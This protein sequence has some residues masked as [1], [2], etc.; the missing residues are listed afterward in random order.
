MA[1]GPKGTIS[2]YLYH[3]PY[4][5]TNILLLELTKAKHRATYGNWDCVG[6]IKIQLWSSSQVRKG[7]TFTTT[8]HPKKKA[9]LGACW[10]I[11]LETISKV[12]PS[13]TLPRQG[14]LKDSRGWWG[15][16]NSR[17]W[18]VKNLSPIAPSLCKDVEN[19]NRI[20]GPDLSNLRREWL[21]PSRNTSAL[22]MSRSLWILLNCTSMWRLNGLPYLVTSL[23]GISFVTIE[24]L[25]S[26]TAKRILDTL[27]RVI[28]IY[29]KAG[30]VVQTALMDI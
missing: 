8:T 1:W 21:G 13:M 18:Y 30:F 24:Y 5:I 17:E 11:S 4:G 26:R 20:F 14:R 12:T 19:A 16:K 15:T 7:L 25:Q 23:W 28:R 22:N 6:V 29:G 27:E 10:W 2:I 9:I 3:N